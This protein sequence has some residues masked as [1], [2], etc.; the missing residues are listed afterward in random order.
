MIIK[1][2]RKEKIELLKALKMGYIDTEKI[3]TL[4]DLVTKYRP[5]RDLTKEEIIQLEKWLEEEY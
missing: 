2:N 3:D 4:N 5:A 1:I